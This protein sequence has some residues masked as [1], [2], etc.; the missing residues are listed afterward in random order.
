MT[1]RERIAGR[2]GLRPGLDRQHVVPHGAVGPE[3]PFES[4]QAMHW[5]FEQYGRHPLD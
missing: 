4:I 1:P 5:A 2:I 3:V